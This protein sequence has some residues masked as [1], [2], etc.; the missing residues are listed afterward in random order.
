[1]LRF[2]VRPQI[3]CCAAGLAD[4]S[5][6]EQALFSGGRAVRHAELA[7]GSD[8]S[9]AL[10]AIGATLA[11]SESPVIYRSLD[12]TSL[13]AC[14]D[15]C[16]EACL[17]VAAPPPSCGLLWAC[18]CHPRIQGSR[19]LAAKLDV[20]AGCSSMHIIHALDDVRL[21]CRDVA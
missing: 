8:A 19:F 12:Y 11:R 21:Q 9:V 3:L 20:R 17:E 10:H 7:A 6:R 13:P 16:M 14:G 4:G 2:W 5:G 15:S 18:S 1:V